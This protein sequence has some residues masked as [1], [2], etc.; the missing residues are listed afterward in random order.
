ML[1]STHEALL[2]NK[3]RFLGPKSDALE[4]RLNCICLIPIWTHFDFSLPNRWSKNRYA[5]LCAIRIIS[6]WY[7]G[8]TIYSK[9]NEHFELR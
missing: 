5:E 2:K 4:E 9:G 1:M 3:V 8:V 6:M 7:Y